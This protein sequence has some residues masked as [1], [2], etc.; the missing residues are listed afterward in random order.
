[1]RNIFMSNEKIGDESVLKIA[2]KPNDWHSWFI[3]DKRT[4]SIRLFVRRHLAISNLAGKTGKNGHQLVL[5]EFAKGDLSQGILVNGHRIVNKKSKRCISTANNQNTDNTFVTYW[6]CSGHATQKW[7]RIPVPGDSE[8]LCKD[9]VKKGGRRFRECPG[10]PPKFLGMKCKRVIE[11]KGQHEFLVKKCGEQPSVQIARC[12][13]Y[14]DKGQWMR[15]CGGT[16]LEQV[17]NGRV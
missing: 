5:R 1:M 8:E 6:P 10:Q 3:M 11:K 17:K 12:E 2:K 14:K 15:K 13:R 9:I 4:S 16:Y 7:D